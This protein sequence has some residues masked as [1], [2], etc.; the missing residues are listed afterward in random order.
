MKFRDLKILADSCVEAD[1]ASHFQEMDVDDVLNASLVMIRVCGCY[2]FKRIMESNMDPELAGQLWN[3]AGLALRE[4]VKAFT[5]LDMH[6]VAKG[7]G[8]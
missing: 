4:W 7:G 5:G 1:A 2:N 6:E 3:T 8:E